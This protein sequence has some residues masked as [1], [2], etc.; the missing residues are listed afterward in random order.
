MGTI[1]GQPAEPVAWT[2]L[3]GGKKARIFYTS[4]GAP[5]DFTSADFRR[6]LS[7]AVTWA[8]GQ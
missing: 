5:E 3:F 1:A 8:L 7:N 2:R 4:L 6:F